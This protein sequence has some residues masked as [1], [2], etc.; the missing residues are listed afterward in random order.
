MFM[1]LENLLKGLKFGVKQ[2]VGA[3]SVLPLI[4][5]DVTNRFASFEDVKF[6]GTTNYGTMIFRNESE[7]PFIVPTGFSVIT[8]QLAQ[9]HAL[10]FATMLKP[11][12]TQSIYNACC[13]QQTQGG[14]IDGNNLKEDFSILPLFVRKKHFETYIKP[15]QRGNKEGLTFAQDDFAR[16]WGIISEFQKDL[17]DRN[18][19]NIVLFFNKF[20]DQLNKFNAE[21]EV[22][23]GQRGAIIMLNDKVVGIEIAPTQAYW[24]TIWN[25]LI[26]DCYGA[27]VIRR[28]MLNLVEEFKASQETALDLDNCMSIEAIEEELAR[29]N[30]DCVKEASSLVNEILQN[31]T[32]SLSSNDTLV[33]NNSF[34]DFNYTLFKVKG[35]STYGEAYFNDEDVV[36]ASILA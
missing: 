21:F 25:G 34:E 18:E 13:I 32:E 26:R 4:G 33:E 30:K 31:E 29:Y 9:D 17:I 22:V 20:V 8:K 36:Y 7:K 16:L 1:K 14:Y 24:Q 28:T 5:E 11:N 2:K 23:N 12:N 19:G 35:S 3:M 6:Q 10:T 27:E 15:N